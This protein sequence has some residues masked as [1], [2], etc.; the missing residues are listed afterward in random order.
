M[1][2]EAK[3]LAMAPLKFLPTSCFRYNLEEEST[4]FQIPKMI[5]NKVNTSFPVQGL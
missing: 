3:C 1:V 5:L 2:Y 4:K